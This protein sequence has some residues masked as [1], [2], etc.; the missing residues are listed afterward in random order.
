MQLHEIHMH[1]KYQVA[2]FIIAKVIANVKVFGRTH[3]LTDRLTDS[4]TAICH[5]TGGI[6][7]EKNGGHQSREPT[8]ARNAILNLRLF[9]CEHI[10]EFKCSKIEKNE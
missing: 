7:I 10:E 8:F 3:R 4:S 1:A 5:P 9:T 6:I 2:I